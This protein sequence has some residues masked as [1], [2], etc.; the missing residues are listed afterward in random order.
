LQR[1]RGNNFVCFLPQGRLAIRALE[2]VPSPDDLF[3]G[4]QSTPANRSS[5]LSLLIVIAA[6][7]VG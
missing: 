5:T 1:P 2:E 3:A 4:V 7:V 6:V